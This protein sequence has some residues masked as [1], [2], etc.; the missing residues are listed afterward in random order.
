MTN[1]SSKTNTT[2]SPSASTVPG[3]QPQPTLPQRS[4]GKRPSGVVR[5][6]YA[7]GGFLLFAGGLLAVGWG[8]TLASRLLAVTGLVATVTGGT[9]YGRC[10]FDE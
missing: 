4:S 9:M 10:L 7:L 2:T 8:L 6:G 1:E 3:S 5:F